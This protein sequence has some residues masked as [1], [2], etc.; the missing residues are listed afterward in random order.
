MENVEIDSALLLE[1]EL[2]R[3]VKE[4]VEGEV[5]RAVVNQIGKVIAAER[6][7]MLMEIS[8]TLG[9]I[10]HHAESREIRPLWESKPEEFGLRPSDMRQ[11]FNS[12]EPVPNVDKDLYI[13]EIEHAVR[14]QT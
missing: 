12:Q 11:R 13:E 9:K 6:D 1:N 14:K 5:E 3:R 10:M 7:K 2:K 4:L 8:I